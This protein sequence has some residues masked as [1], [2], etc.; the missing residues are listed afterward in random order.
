MPSILSR[1]T[2]STRHGARG[3]SVS[4]KASASSWRDVSVVGETSH[5]YTINQNDPYFEGSMTGASSASSGMQSSSSQ[6]MG[7]SSNSLRRNCSMN[8]SDFMQVD[9]GSSLPP[10][11]YPTAISSHGGEETWG[12]FVDVAAKEEAIVKH[13]R[14]LSSDSGSSPSSFYSR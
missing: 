1:N 7:K 4:M 14:I 2:L 10:S 8:F 5:A 13:S 3:S 12:H 6:S 11:R 9:E